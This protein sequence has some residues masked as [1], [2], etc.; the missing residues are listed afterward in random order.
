[1]NPSST[2]NP[3]PN[4][5]PNPSPMPVSAG[6]MPTEGRKHV[7][8]TI[9]LVV[10]ILIAFGFLGWKWFAVQQ[11]TKLLEAQ[12]AAMQAD[13][14]ATEAQSV[15]GDGDATAASSSDGSDANQASESRG[16]QSADTLDAD[17][18]IILN[19]SS[20]EDLKSIDR[21]F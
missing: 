8:L 6:A 13:F 3:T 14:S 9:S 7:A 2:P 12:N 15:S 16:I 4:P 20:E 5:I 17:M 10:L 19:S 21:E 11:E 1:M 18:S